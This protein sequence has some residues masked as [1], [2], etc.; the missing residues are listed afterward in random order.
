MT[1]FVAIAAACAVGMLVTASVAS[2]A[3]SKALIGTQKIAAKSCSKD[4][5][6]CTGWRASCRRPNSKGQY[7][8]KATNFYTDGSTCLIG[9]TWFTDG[10]KLFLEKAGKPRCF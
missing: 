2:G 1:K 3:P 8:C 7:K 6:V 4:A 9:L 10:G 5:K